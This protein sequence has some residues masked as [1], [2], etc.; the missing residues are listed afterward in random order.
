LSFA[1]TSRIRENGEPHPGEPAELVEIPSGVVE[2]LVFDTLKH[3]R[4]RSDSI[5]K[6]PV[7]TLPLDSCREE[8]GL[9]ICVCGAFYG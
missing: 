6:D 3:A 1:T 8:K 2:K 4:N 9:K 5:Y 7:K